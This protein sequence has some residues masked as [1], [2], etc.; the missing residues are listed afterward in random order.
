MDHPAHGVDRD[1]GDIAYGIEMAYAEIALVARGDRNRHDACAA[2]AAGRDQQGGFEDEMLGGNV[3]QVEHGTW[4]QALAALRI[5]DGLCTGAG[6][7]PV[8]NCVGA[9]AARRLLVAVQDAGTDDDAAGILSTR[10]QDGGYVGG[11]VLAVAVHGDHGIETLAQHFAEARAQGFA[12][13]AP[14]RMAEQGHRQCTDDLGRAVVRPVVD[15]DDRQAQCQ[16]FG[17]DASDGAFLVEAGDQHADPIGACV[18]ASIPTS[19]WRSSSRAVAMRNAVACA[20]ASACISGMAWAEG[21]L[22]AMPSSH[23]SPVGWL[24]LLPIDGVMSRRMAP[25]TACGER[26]RATAKGP[27]VAVIS[28]SG[29]APVMS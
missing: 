19:I 28:P 7:P 21:L 22:A 26:T 1:P 2:L 12:L 14:L 5:R 29:P 4:I 25:G 20:S 16:R 9:A 18:H 11:Q 27:V 13:A 24:P 8:G 3:D 17:D 15:H 23:A 10:G 6:N